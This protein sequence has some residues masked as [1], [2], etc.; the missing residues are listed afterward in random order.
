MDKRTAALDAA[1]LVIAREGMRG[2]THRAVDAVAGLPLGSTSNYFRTRHALV[3]GV[4]DRLVERDREDMATAGGQGPRTLEEVAQA[5]A[6]Y[7]RLSVG[8]RVELTRARYALFAEAA[9]SPAL[10]DVLLRRREELTDLGVRLLAGVDAGNPVARWRVEAAMGML[11]GLILQRLTG[12]DGEDDVAAIRA[13][14]SV[15]AD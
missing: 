15:C 3:A 9:G 14:L 2:L 4:F 13:A 1:L 7:L 12:T 6:G 8:P 11:D 10:R 5:L